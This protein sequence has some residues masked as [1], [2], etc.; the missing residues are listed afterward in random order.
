MNIRATFVKE[1]VDR[2][3]RGLDLAVRAEAVRLLDHLATMAIR[4][5]QTFDRELGH[6]ALAE[7]WDHTPVV[8]TQDTLSMEVFS[9][10]EDMIFYNKTSRADI[11][12]VHSSKYF[13]EGDRLL[14]ILEGGARPHSISATGGGLLAIPLPGTE[15]AAKSH[16]AAHGPGS[17]LPS[18]YGDTVFQEHVDHPGVQANQ[19]I[20]TTR[21]MIEQGLD[22]EVLAALRNIAVTLVT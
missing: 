8:E 20:E 15:S 10:A 16:V 3:A 5:L 19:N 2:M 9:H 17:Y 6:E 4:Q 11:G 7:L 22:A 14:A 21:E 1:D 18:T 12:R 13:I